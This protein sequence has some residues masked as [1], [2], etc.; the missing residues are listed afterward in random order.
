ME[1]A[2]KIDEADTPIVDTKS[3]MP[4]DCNTYLRPRGFQELFGNFPPLKQP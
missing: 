2:I 3:G 4:V 1:L